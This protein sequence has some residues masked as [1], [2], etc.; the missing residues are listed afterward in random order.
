MT[1][2]TFSNL[3]GRDLRS[4]EKK[5]EEFLVVCHPSCRLPPVVHYSLWDDPYE[6]ACAGWPFGAGCGLR[7]L[8]GRG[9]RRGIPDLFT[10]R[11]RGSDEGARGPGR[12]QGCKFK[13]I[14][15]F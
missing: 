8:H 12:A 2:L 14:E 15:R 7:G 9:V 11:A 6:A 1:S 4:A 3:E 5:G 10:E 13:R